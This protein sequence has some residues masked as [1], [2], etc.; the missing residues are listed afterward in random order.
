MLRTQVRAAVVGALLLCAF[1]LPHAAS[2]QES[3]ESILGTITDEEGGVEGVQILVTTADG[4]EVGSATTDG[5]GAWEVPVP[6]PGSYSVLVVEETLPDGAALRNPD[7]NP[8]EMDV[9]S[10]QNRRVLFPLGEGTRE[11]AAWLGRLISLTVDGIKFGL[12]IGMCA[13]GLSLIFGTTGLVNFAHGELVA[14]GAIA[15]WYLNVRGAQLPLILAGLIAIA[16]G[17]ALAGGLEK[18]LWSP[19]RRRGTGLIS[20]LVVSIGLS[21][22]LR[23]ILLL[24]FGG[25]SLPFRQYTVQ[26]AF[27]LGPLSITP[28]D[29]TIVILSAAVLT[30]VGLLLTMTKIGKAMRAVADNRDLAES[31]GIDVQRVI[32]YVWMLGGGL[33]AMGGVLQGVSE[34][35][36]WNMGFLLLLLMF[37][38]VILGGIGTAFGALVGS[39][40][41]GI[42]TQVSTLWFPAELKTVFAL[43]ALALVLMFRPQGILGRAE[44]IG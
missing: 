40:V 15:A 31:S 44:R 17:A 25:R 23:H 10:G 2:A 20:M 6:G 32:L 9:L 39:L 37:A 4:G 36:N 35:V 21:L 19:L 1:F 5:E 16:L 27:D 12:I 14:F 22:F 33:A 13:I 11:T 24:V 18:G 43:L 30:G 3:N 34:A 28:R 8:L 7:R 26:S 38:G 29:L 41:V 42:I